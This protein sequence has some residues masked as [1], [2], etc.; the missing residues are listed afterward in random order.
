MSEGLNVHRHDG[1]LW[2]DYDFYY[3]HSVE[4]AAR[5]FDAAAAD[6]V[7]GAEVM[8]LLRSATDEDGITAREARQIY[9]ALERHFD[10]MD[11]NARHDS[12]Q[13]L[14]R[15]DAAY[16]GGLQP[17]DFIQRGF[18]SPAPLIYQDDEK[19]S[20]AADY[21]RIKG[22][23]MRQLVNDTN[24]IAQPIAHAI[25]GAIHAIGL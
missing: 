24:A 5:T 17:P 10:Q 1:P 2:F 14:D 16:P 22:D 13:L 25:W 23:D 4:A 20:S 11:G 9:G 15:L 7:N 6:G 18:W 8:D 21:T 12:Q 19:F 3:D